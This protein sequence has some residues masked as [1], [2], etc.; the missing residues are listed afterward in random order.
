MPT[1]HR[2]A[3]LVRYQ[4]QRF[5]AMSDDLVQIHREMV[6]GMVEDHQT[7]TSGTLSAKDLS[8]LGHPYA[9]RAGGAGSRG[10][11]RN[12]SSY[13]GRGLKGWQTTGGRWAQTVKP[14]IGRAGAISGLPINRNT[15]RLQRS[16]FLTGPVGKK[17]EY[18]VGFTAPYAGF[19][20]APGGTSKMVARGFY[21]NGGQ[22]GI[23]QR[24][25][26]ARQ[27]AFV[28][29]QRARLQRFRS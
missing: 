15:G 21:S 17:H 2:V 25:H 28:R 11:V 18:R 16:L 12:A 14:Q 27:S 24:N 3:D 5:A 19:V 9:R 8:R 26:K 29:V 7:Y 20:L 13:S 23:I 10:A 1:F 22:L 6:R 4:E